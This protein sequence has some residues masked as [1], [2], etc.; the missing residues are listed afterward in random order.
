MERG[1]KLKCWYCN[2]I[3]ATV[4]CCEPQCVK[5][6]HLP[7]GIKNGAINEYYG[8]FNSYCPKHK[9]KRRASSNYVLT[10]IGLVPESV[11]Q[12]ASI[13]DAKCDKKVSRNNYKNTKDV[14]THKEMPESKES[15]RYL[16]ASITATSTNG[17]AKRALRRGT[18]TRKRPE[19]LE[20]GGSSDEE[21]DAGS[22]SR[23][24]RRRKIKP[25]NNDVYTSAKHELEKLLKCKYVSINDSFSDIAKLKKRRK[26]AKNNDADSNVKEEDKSSEMMKLASDKNFI[27]I[28][29]EN[30]D[31][32]Q[33]EKQ[34][35]KKEETIADIEQFL[36]ETE[37]GTGSS[38]S[39]D[40]DPLLD[41]HDPLRTTEL[42]NSVSNEEIFSNTVNCQRDTIVESVVPDRDFQEISDD[43]NNFIG[44]DIIDSLRD[45]LDSRVC[46]Y[47]CKLCLYTSSSKPGVKGH[48]STDHADK[49]SGGMVCQEMLLYL[50]NI[51]L[52]EEQCRTALEDKKDEIYGTICYMRDMERFTF[53]HYVSDDMP[54]SI[55]DISRVSSG[56]DVCTNPFYQSENDELSHHYLKSDPNQRQYALRKSPEKCNDQNGEKS[57]VEEV[58]NSHE[59]SPCTR[60]ARCSQRRRRDPS[61]SPYDSELDGDNGAAIGLANGHSMP[62]IAGSLIDESP[63]MNAELVKSLGTESDLPASGKQFK[64]LYSTVEQHQKS[65]GKF[66]I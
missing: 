29:E 44:V 3:C 60:S 41:D 56:K 31:V 33:T 26:L 22:S 54:D 8:H 42:P 48:I 37:P 1:S 53:F 27:E 58:E 52:K 63:T 28:K 40:L 5:T 64:L 61:G 49:E 30:S 43:E 19:Y 9:H 15:R 25:A 35:I 4:G 13:K 18:M 50:T 57:L 51:N 55:S 2:E 36:D 65:Q 47:K 14:Q 16:T 10:D 6:Y 34:E 21:P 46:M 20:S 11:E 24:R 12:R 39:Q 23:P 66:N 32:E 45:R 62:E 59:T 38:G 17:K 7:C